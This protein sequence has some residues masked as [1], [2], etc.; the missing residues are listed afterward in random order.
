ME[1]LGLNFGLVI[2]Y[3]I[4]GFLG[5]YAL[6]QRVTPIKSLLHGE[7]GSPE[8]GAII[9]LLIVAMAV[10]MIINALGWIIVRPLI[11]IS[12]VKRPRDLDYT[13]LKVE[14]IKLYNVIVEANF[15]YHQ[16][17]TNMFFAI[18][19]LIPIWVVRPIW[20][21]RIRNFSLLIVGLALFL[22]ARDSLNRAYTRM[23]AL[24]NKEDANVNAQRGPRGSGRSRRRS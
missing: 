19:L 18:L 3:L 4:P 22:A 21:N 7:K 6:S 8:T 23:S 20:D 9:P 10:G 15:R 16:F 13:K 1:K 5:L 12:G 2:A 24:Q 17:Y 14:D 11:T